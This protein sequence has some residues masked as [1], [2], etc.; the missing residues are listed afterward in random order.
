[1]LQQN[2]GT[3]NT[4]K[5]S[6]KVKWL[7]GLSEESSMDG[8]TTD[9]NP[10]SVTSTIDSPRINNSEFDSFDDQIKDNTFEEVEKCSAFH[11]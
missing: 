2:N 3:M 10:K 5:L 6:K 8:N 9:E 1:M 11:E 7:E 4:Y